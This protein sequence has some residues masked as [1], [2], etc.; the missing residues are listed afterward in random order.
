MAD[1]K[2]YITPLRE[3]NLTNR[4]LFDEVME[5]PEIHREVLGIIFGKEITLLEQ[6]ETE[7]EFRIS[8]LARS[9]RLDVFSVDS[10]KNV[11]NTELQQQRKKDLPK[12]SRYYQSLMDSSLLEPGVLDYNSL[13]N[14]YI[15]L[16]MPFDLFGFKKYCYTFKPTCKEAPELELE[17][18]TT[19]IFLNTR[20][21]NDDE[22]SPELIDFLHYVENTTD[23]NAISSESS[24]IH[25]IHE[26]VTRIRQNEEM[27]VRYMRAYEEKHFDIEAGIK[28]GIKIGLARGKAE[29]HSAGLAE[30]HSAGLA[31]GRSESLFFSVKNLMSN[32][33]FSAEESMRALGM[34][35][36]EKAV[37]R[38]RL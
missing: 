3:A 38:A 35:E 17:D 22:V 33:G 2:S 10:E 16:I 14:T 29:G 19:R 34:S 8:P 30:G 7:K 5:D 12:R 13:N 36:S 27:G 25:K 37:C 15:I 1:K 18:G 6:N 32:M 11:Y 26:R 9:V 23:E 28:Q 24:R 21:T 31:E 4:F 20:G